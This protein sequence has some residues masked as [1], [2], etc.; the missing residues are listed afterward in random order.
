MNNTLIFVNSAP[1]SYRLPFGINTNVVLKNV[2]NEIRR[3]KNGIKTTKNC[4]M[5]FMKVDAE[6]NQS[7][8]ESTFSYFNLEK[9]EY[10]SQNLITQFNQISEI[11]SAV[12]PSDSVMEVKQEIGGVLAEHI[13]TMKKIKGGKKN[14]SSKL[15]K[16][17]SAVQKDLSDKFS[18]VIKPFL[19]DSG[20]KVAL[21][22]VTGPN[23]KFLDLPKIDKGF[24]IK[25]GTKK[26]LKLDKKYVDWYANKDKKEKAS[27][28]AMGDDIVLDEDD[29][30]LDDDGLE[31]ID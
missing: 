4:Y 24:V 6:T 17:L 11:V 19:G 21:L 14:V 16:E 15:L 9:P 26:V 20:D 7:L 10:A 12:V 18:D 28:D 27:P 31:G 5:T 1:S 30:N 29:I 22:I 25:E 23:G 13:E 3:D 2:D 8:A